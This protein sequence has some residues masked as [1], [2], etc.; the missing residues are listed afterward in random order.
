MR[1]HFSFA[2][3]LVA[4][5]LVV[6]LTGCATVSTVEPLTVPLVYTVDPDNNAPLASFSC[7]YLAG[8][9]VVDK[10]SDTVLGVRYHESKPL[11]ADVSV[12]GD[13]LL[14][15]HGGLE[16]YLAQNNIKAGPSGPKLVIE[17]DSLKTSEN[18]LHRSGYEARITG[19]AS[20]ESAS[21]KSCWHAAVESDKGNYGYVG[22][23]KDY[24]EVLN[25]ALDKIGSEIVSSPDFTV[26]LCHC[27]D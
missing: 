21:G 19:N 11:K 5:P 25:R 3:L 7:P 23:I 14:W 6:G 4:A 12:G 10:R 26:V 13:P 22:S 15:I 8:I 17:L 9:S 24:Q 2:S 18:I 16:S 27:A 20:L 1:H